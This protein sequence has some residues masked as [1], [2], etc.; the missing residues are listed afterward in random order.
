MD[1]AKKIHFKGYR[2]FITN[3]MIAVFSFLLVSC[4]TTATP[5]VDAMIPDILPLKTIN[6]DIEHIS[7]GI[8]SELKD[9]WWYPSKRLEITSYSSQWERALIET[10]KNSHRFKQGSKNKLYLSVTV[11][12][13]TSLPSFMSIRY[14]VKAK[15][16]ITEVMT[17]SVIYS[18]D[19]ETVGFIP[20]IQSIG[21]TDSVPAAETAVNENIKEFMD[22]IDA[23]NL[24]GSFDK[25]Q[26]LG[27]RS[28]LIINVLNLRQ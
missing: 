2:M 21:V 18:N 6:A 14:K 9:R 20:T 12:N 8:S 15:Y 13:M 26:T 4:S 3:L 16:Q 17:G 1:L 7:F 27:G 5:S 19:I 25:N 23:E 10:I 24:H 22:S 11:L 28:Q